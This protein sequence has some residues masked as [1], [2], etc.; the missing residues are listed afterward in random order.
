MGPG[1]DDDL[2]AEQGDEPR[3]PHFAV[4]TSRGTSPDRAGTKGPFCA[5]KISVCGAEIDWVT[6]GH[7]RSRSFDA[8]VFEMRSGKVMRW[9]VAALTPPSAEQGRN[10]SLV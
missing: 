4:G 7:S 8:T 5:S 10:R 2:M 6:R 3:Q 9:H 1:A